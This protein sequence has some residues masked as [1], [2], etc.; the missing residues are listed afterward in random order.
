MEEA[1]SGIADSPVHTV[2]AGRTDA[3]VHA[4]GQVVHFETDAIRPRHAWI[5]G[6][7]TNL[8]RAISVLWAKPVPDEFHARFSARSRH[9]RYRI[10]N[11]PVRPALYRKHITW[12]RRPLAVDRMQAGADYLIGEHDFSAFR[13]AACQATNPIRAIHT[14]QVTRHGEHIL[15]DV[16]ANAFLY[17]M[18]RN[19][20]GV[21]MAIGTGKQPPEWAARVLATRDRTKGAVTAPAE[22]LYLVGVDYPE[23]FRIPRGAI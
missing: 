14:L 10:L 4:R 9:Y 8:P 15:I 21:L 1:L 11:R 22:G 13:A 18:V 23:H 17:H 7:N 2:C 12:E 16:I 3:G 6:T 20:A 5:I 19:I